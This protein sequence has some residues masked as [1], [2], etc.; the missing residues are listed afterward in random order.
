MSDVQVKLN[1]KDINVPAGSTIL[2]AAV[3][4]GFDVPTLCNAEGLKPF[5]SCFVCAVKVEGG[6]GNLVP[7]CATVV[8]DGMNITV[9]SPEID[10]ARKMCISLLVSDHCG[11]CLPPCQS[12][13]PSSIDIKGFLSEIAGGKPEKAASLI[14]EKAPLPGVLGRVCPRPCETECRRNRVEDAIAVCN[15]KRFASDMEIEKYGKIMLPEPGRSTGFKTAVIGAGPAGMTAA[16]FLRLKGHDVT[17]FEKNEKSGGMLRYGIP[18]YRLPD[19]VLAAEMDALEGT[20]I[21]VRYGVE[22]GKDIPARELEKD[23]NALLIAVGAQGASS[24]RIEGEDLEGVYTG[25]DYLRELAE[26]RI[27]DLG[28]RVIVVGGGNTAIDAARSALRAGADVTILYRRTRAEMPASDF[29]I[30]EALEEGVRIEFL[31]APAGISRREGK[32]VIKSIRMRMGEPDSS[33]RRRPVPIEGSDFDIEADSIISAI[34][35]RVLP[36]C[37]S[38]LGIEIDRSGDIVSD[39]ETF[40]TSRPG[41]FSAGDCQSGADIAV[42]AIGNARKAAEAIHQYLLSKPVT[43]E[44]A[45]FNSTMGPLETVPEELFADAEKAERIKMPMI[46]RK[47]R[48]TSFNEIEK[49]FIDE[50]A[51]KEAE[52]CLKCGCDKIDDCRLREYA[53]RFNVDQGLFKGEMRG[54]TIDKTRDDIKLEQGKCISCGSCVRACAE[55]KG[56]NVFSFVNRGFRTRMTVPFGRSLV[57]SA[58]DGCGECAKVC[59]TAAIMMTGEKP[60]EAVSY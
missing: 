17:V 44:K 53:T 9:E 55:I 39:Y 49:G 4:G 30:E 43:G 8:R 46:S 21:E 36:E 7:S 11:D 6:K 33:G 25:I 28:S 16:Y 51:V 34:G 22:I 37:V 35:Q 3:K 2:D 18:Y 31:A 54:Y 42:R 50:D 40:M 57:D 48:V 32:V 23:Y 59:P 58:C 38:D 45:E 19:N 10:S 13:C 60:E 52:R 1:G 5:T 12:A 56:L 29:E 24:M 20:G 26:G 15:M 27:P 41:I 14:R 47:A